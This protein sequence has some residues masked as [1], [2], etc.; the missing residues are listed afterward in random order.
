MKKNVEQ[1]THKRLLFLLGIISYFLLMFGNGIIALTHPDEVFY[2]Q[3]AK[4]MVQYNS[5]LTP[6]IFDEPHFEKPFLAC[7]LGPYM[8]G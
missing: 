8:I 4:E 2:I 5:W 7:F 3:T 1:Y 6:M